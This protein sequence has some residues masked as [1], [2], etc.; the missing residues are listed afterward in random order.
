M[1]GTSEARLGRRSF[2]QGL[3]GLAAGSLLVPVSAARAGGSAGGAS[4]L[5]DEADR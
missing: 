5:L 4:G 1:D 2:L 3:A